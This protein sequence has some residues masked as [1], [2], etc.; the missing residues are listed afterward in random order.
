MALKDTLIAINFLV[1]GFNFLES[2]PHQ[3]QHVTLLQG[4]SIIVMIFI[5]VLVS[6]F[7][8]WFLLLLV[9]EWIIIIVIIASKWDEVVF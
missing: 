9:I 4:I 1:E 2:I 6:K 5:I 8:C 7:L 3:N